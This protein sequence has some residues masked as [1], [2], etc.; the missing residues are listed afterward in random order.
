MNAGPGALFFI[1]DFERAAVEPFDVDVLKPNRGK[2]RRLIEYGERFRL[3]ACGRGGRRQTRRQKE[4][5]NSFHNSLP[6]VSGTRA[7]IPVAARVRIGC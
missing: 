5:E 3:R 4:R 1:R 7:E 2:V 6:E